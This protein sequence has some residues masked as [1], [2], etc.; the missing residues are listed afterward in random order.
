[1]TRKSLLLGRSN[2][3]ARVLFIPVLKVLKLTTSAEKISG[4]HASAWQS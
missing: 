1:M 2:K 3:H 4:D